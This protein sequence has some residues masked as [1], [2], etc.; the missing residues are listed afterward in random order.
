MLFAVWSGEI[1]RPTID[2][3]LLGYGKDSSERVEN[4]FREVCSVGVSEDGIAFDT[5]SVQATPIRE[6]QSYHGQRVTL[7][8]RL[9][10]ARIHVQVDIGFGD[11]VTPD[12][13]QIEYPTLLELPAPRI[14]ACPRET[15]VAEKLHAMVVLG[16]ANS[17]MKDFYDMHVLSSRFDFAGATL[18]KAIQATFKRRKTEIPSEV[19][20]ALSKEFAQDKTKVIQW[21]AFAK[22]S[23]L[24]S[25]DDLE[26]TI[27]EMREFLLLPL[28]AA[29]GKDPVPN[30]W[31]AG[32]CWS[33]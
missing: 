14:K 33:G 23:G 15:V 3:D 27:S 4:I 26:L 2:V 7:T 13:E 24:S 16:I 29:A 17:R 9:G 1:H 32:G 22:K 10:K 21:K 11:V 18:V 28:K 5:E 31:E 20:L 8:A 12:A 25:I 30:R 6:G 19:P